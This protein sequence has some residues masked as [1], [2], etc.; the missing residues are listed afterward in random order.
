MCADPVLCPAAVAPGFYTPEGGSFA[1][2][3]PQGTFKSQPGAATACTACPGG[4]I[5]TGLGSTS[6]AD[7]TVMLPGA[8]PVQMNGSAV[9]EAKLCP[10]MF[11]CGGGVP[12]GPVNPANLAALNPAEPTIKACP[13]GSW[14]LALQA[15]SVEECCE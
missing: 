9:L 11:Y 14:T 12:L 6:L 7:C 8:Y 4:V 5:T 15:A 13:D 1:V 3:C 10:Q 2:E